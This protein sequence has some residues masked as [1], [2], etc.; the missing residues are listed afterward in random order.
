[1]ELNKH[2]GELSGP[3]SVDESAEIFVLAVLPGSWYD[4]RVFEQS[5]AVLQDDSRV[6]AARMKREEDA[7]IKREEDARMQGMAADAVASVLRVAGSCVLDMVF[8]TE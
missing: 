5:I 7:R 4:A 3:A 6:Q 1:M 8:A 2:T